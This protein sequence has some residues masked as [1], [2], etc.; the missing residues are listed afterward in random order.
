MSIVFRARVT[1]SARRVAPLVLTLFFAACA[2]RSG[3]R[4]PTLLLERG[5]F[6]QTISARGEL[7]A[8]R[9]VDVK[10]PARLSGWQT[11][12]WIMPEGRYVKKGEVLIVLSDEIIAADERQATN[13][14]D[15]QNLRIEAK[16]R[17]LEKDRR[18]VRNRQE[19]S[20][21]ELDLAE[22]FALTDASLFSKY[23]IIDSQTSR[24]L[25]DQK[26]EHYQRKEETIEARAKTEFELLQIQRKTHEMKIEQ[27]EEA[28]KSLEIKAP[29]DGIFFYHRWWKDRLQV[30]MKVNP[31]WEVGILPDLSEMEAKVF[32]LESEAAGLV[33]GLAVDLVLDSHPGRV[34]SGKVQRVHS[35]AKAKDRKSPVKYFEAVVALDETVVGMMRPGAAVGVTIYVEREEDVL[36]VPNQAVF[37]DEKEHWVFVKRGRGFERRTVKTGARSTTRT[38]LTEGVEAGEEVALVNPKTSQEA[39]GAL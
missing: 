30:G 14:V 27:L 26:K 31:G 15:L 34:F 4:I 18:E 38:V 12:R 10:I 5:L 11:I 8:V 20:Q 37:H 33:E 24:E 3:T 6:E 13:K 25:L 17:E 16:E 2:D 9:H 19:L 39:G 29:H 7:K 22:D 36:S 28:R 32:V 21:E 23:E 35:L 1:R